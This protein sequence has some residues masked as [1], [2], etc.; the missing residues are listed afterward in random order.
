MESR[1]TSQS[2]NESTEA[3]RTEDATRSVRAILEGLKKAG[4]GFTG[5][6]RPKAALRGVE[7]KVVA[8]QDKSLTMTWLVDLNLGEFGWEIEGTSRRFSPG[9]N[10]A[11]LQF[12]MHCK[13]GRIETTF[14]LGSASRINLP[15]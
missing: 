10:P 4:P 3:R 5:L 2:G 13:D 1:T 6:R 7:L 12:T 15:K 8:H 11:R 9:A 14:V